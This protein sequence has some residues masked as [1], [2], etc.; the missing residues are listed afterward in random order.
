MAKE[1]VRRPAR[2]MKPIYIVFC[3]GETEANYVSFLRLQYRVPIKVIPK[4]TGQKI[5]QALIDRHVSAERIAKDDDISSFVMYDLDVPGVAAQLLKCKAIQLT[6]NPCVELWFL[7]HECEQ[8]AAI[9]TDAC[10]TKLKRISSNW[11]WYTKGSL[12]KNQEKIL[13]ENVS[14]A[15][16]RAKSLASTDN[17]SSTVYHLIEKL[18]NVLKQE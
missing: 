7:L 10:M 2:T 18:E 9:A 14:I 3:E 4:I 12:T 13:R 16:E 5:S 17:P 8:H 15:I 11:P 1:R 6:S